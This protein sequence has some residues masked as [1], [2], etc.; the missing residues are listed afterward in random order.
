VAAHVYDAVNV[1]STTSFSTVPSSRLRRGLATFAPRSPLLRATRRWSWG[2]CPKAGREMEID[3]ERHRLR[4]ADEAHVAAG[5]LVVAIRLDGRDG[6]LLRALLERHGLAAADDRR[7]SDARRRIDEPLDRHGAFPTTP[8]EYFW[9]SSVVV[10]DPS[11]AWT[12]FF[13]DGST[14]SFAMTKPQYARCVR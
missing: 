3:R 11:R 10:D 7:D 4:H 9:S 8:S 5:D 13:A 12:C 14:Y 1:M 2:S 6:V